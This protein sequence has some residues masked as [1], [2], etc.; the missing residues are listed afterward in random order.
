MTLKENNTHWNLLLKKNSWII[1]LFC[2]LYINF[3]TICHH[4]ETSFLD[5]SLWKTVSGY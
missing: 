2:E 5:C 4:A 3:R 1:Y